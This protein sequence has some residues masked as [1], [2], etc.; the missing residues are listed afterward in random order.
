MRPFG[1]INTEAGAYRSSSA[2]RARSSA[3]AGRLLFGGL[4]R[5]IQPRQG[6]KRRKTHDV[7]PRR[8][9]PT[10]DAPFLR[11]GVKQVLSSPDR[12]RVTEKQVSVL[13]QREVEQSYHPLLR[14]RLEV[15][16]KVAAG[17]QIES[18]EWWIAKQVLRREN[19]EFAQILFD[20]IGPVE[21][22][23]EAPQTRRPDRCSRRCRIDALARDPQI[24]LL[25]VGRKDFETERFTQE[26]GA[27][28]RQHREG[29]GLLAGSACRYPE[30]K[31][32]VS[33]LLCQQRRE[34][35]IVESPPRFPITKEAADADHQVG[36]QRPDLLRVRVQ[37]VGVV[38]QR[39]NT[40]K[41]HASVDAPLERASLVVA[42]VMTGVGPQNC[43]DGIECQLADVSAG[44]EGVRRSHIAMP[45]ITQQRFRQF[46][47]R[48][49]MVGRACGD[50]GA[51][52]TVESRRVGI[53]GQ[54]EAAARLNLLQ[55][56]RP[57]AAS[58]RQN[59]RDRP[60]APLVGERCEEHIDRVAVAARLNRL[61]QAQPI[62]VNGQRLVGRDDVNRIRSNRHAVRDLH[63]R[64]GRM[65]T[66]DG[67]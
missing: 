15:D 39:W 20:L 33:L 64:H 49:N 61:G 29:I 28:S 18:R 36:D 26:F 23:E 46:V 57:V 6:A 40:T 10:I 41:T 31:F 17:D 8:T 5:L 11:N 37:S 50:R 16:Q 24:I 9:E 43:Q 22:V 35:D 51:R 60:L 48:E 19:D 12:F 21:R 13:A 14:L 42:E 3:R 58:T 47:R 55:A 52:H 44:F 7:V 56:L 27:L 30:A 53:L 66:D 32:Y 54:G 65:A 2:R 59:D 1:S 67:S 38:G 34:H 62:P 25:A 4:L 63:D 45:D